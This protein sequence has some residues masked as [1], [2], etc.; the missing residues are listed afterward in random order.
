MKKKVFIML[1]ASALITVYGSANS[2]GSGAHGHDQVSDKVISKQKKSLA[3]NTKG[4]GYGPQSPRDIDSN[5]G[6]N[7]RA[8]NAAPVF[9][10]MNLCNI[11]FHKNA[12]HKGGEFTRYAGNGNGHGYQSGY[13]Y[14]GKLSSAELKPTS[15]KVC[16]NKHGGLSSG[17]TIEVHYVHTTAKVKP[18]PTLGSCLSKSINNPQLRVETQVYVLVNDRNALDFGKLT[19]HGLKNGLHQALNIP[20]NTGA[21]VQYTGSTTGPGYNEKGSPFQVSWSVRP[22]VAKVN[23][24]TVGMWCKGNVFKE[25]HAHGVRNLVTNQDLLSTIK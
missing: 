18:G 12:E 10:S 8:F 7:G 2:K 1:T 4:K 3:K 22:K 24:G 25:D 23:I 5:T 15:H 21:P 20:D 16:P 19:Q 13:R 6:N 11:H 14:S 9:T 17:D